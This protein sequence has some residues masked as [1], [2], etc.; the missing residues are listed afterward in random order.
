MKGYVLWR[1]GS[2]GGWYTYSRHR[3]RWSASLAALWDGAPTRILPVGVEPLSAD[4]WANR[5]ADHEERIMLGR[6]KP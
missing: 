2:H 3:Y 4:S 5:Q 1:H 6:D